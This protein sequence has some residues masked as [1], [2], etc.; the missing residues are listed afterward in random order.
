MKALQRR[1][2]QRQ[3][4]LQRQMELRAEE[5][6][7]EARRQGMRDSER[8]QMLRR[9][10]SDMLEQQ[11]TLLEDYQPSTIAINAALEACVRTGRLR[12][13]LLIYQ[14]DVRFAEQ[15]VRLAGETLNQTE[16]PV[17]QKK[18]MN[19]DE[20]TVNCSRLLYRV[21]SCAVR[22]VNSVPVVFWDTL[23]LPSRRAFLPGEEPRPSKSAGS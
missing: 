5:L 4:G 23:A 8:E 21:C 3:H 18:R 20:Q 19:A 17:G 12:Q 14:E 16:P 11:Q 1:V 9:L 22:G 13:G 6:E 2:L 7:R 15:Q 10:N